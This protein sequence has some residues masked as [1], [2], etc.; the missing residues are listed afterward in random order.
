[1]DSF[2]WEW[3]RGYHSAVLSAMERKWLTWF[4]PEKIQNLRNQELV[5]RSAKQAAITLPTQSAAAPA[6]Q[7]QFRAPTTARKQDIQV[8]IPYQQSQ[9][10]QTR[11]HNG[12]KH[13]CKFCWER[14]GNRFSHTEAAC[15]KKQSRKNKRNNHN[16]DKSSK[17]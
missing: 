5:M 3:V 15:L 14:D 6:P 1:M 9:C 4:T 10:P 16:Q 13:V 8:C 2:P 7:S 12:L 17:N 11:D